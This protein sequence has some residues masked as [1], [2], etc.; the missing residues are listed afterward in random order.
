MRE[1]VSQAKGSSWNKAALNQLT[2]IKGRE[3]LQKA[4]DLDFIQPTLSLV[5]MK[6]QVELKHT[7]FQAGKGTKRRS[8]PVLPKLTK[9]GLHVATGVQDQKSQTVEGIH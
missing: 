4:R 8:W 3:K 2:S 6:W 5:G 7:T 9:H 1:V